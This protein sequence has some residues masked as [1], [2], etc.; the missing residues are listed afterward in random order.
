[1][2]RRLFALVVLLSLMLSAGC[3]TPL[4]GVAWAPVVKV[5]SVL[6]VG[7][8]TVGYD[9][10]GESKW[11]GLLFLCRGDASLAAAMEDGGISQIHHVELEQ[12][13]VLGIYT[14]EIVRVYGQ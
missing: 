14:E 3:H 2:A 12:L 13:S 11:E 10:I 9:K 1:M 7:D 5:K 8:T 4:K 6:A